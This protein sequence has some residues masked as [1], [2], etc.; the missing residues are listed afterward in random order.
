M[1]GAAW[2]KHCLVSGMTMQ[3]VEG[4]IETRGYLVECAS[5]LWIP[6]SPPERLE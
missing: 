2:L 3:W 1:R 4:V 6:S 5:V